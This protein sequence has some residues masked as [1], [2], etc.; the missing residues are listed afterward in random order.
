MLNTLSAYGEV[1]RG[2]CTVQRGLLLQ[3]QEHLK[4]QRTHE[5]DIRDVKGTRLSED[6]IVSMNFRGF[7][8]TVLD[9]LE[10][11][12]YGFLESYT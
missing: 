6:T 2:I 5:G 7:H 3:I 10:R 12:R 8:Q 4:I 11:E 1:N 9:D